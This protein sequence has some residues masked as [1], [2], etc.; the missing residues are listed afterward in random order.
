MHL[1]MRPQPMRIYDSINAYGLSLVL[2]EGPGGD[3]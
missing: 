2:G 1:K 3:E